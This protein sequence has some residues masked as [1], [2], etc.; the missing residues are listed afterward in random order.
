MPEMQ[1]DFDGLIQLLAGHLY[2][3]KKVFI[4]ELIQN[5]HDSVQRRAAA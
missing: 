2:T 5:A 4:R 3:E 1:F